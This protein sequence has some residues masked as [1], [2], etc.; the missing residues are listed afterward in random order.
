MGNKLLPVTIRFTPAAYA[1]ICEIASEQGMSMADVV[2]KGFDRELSD[3]LDNIVYMDYDQGKAIQEQLADLANQMQQILFELHRIG[4]NYNQEIRLRQIAKKY[5]QQ[6]TEIDQKYE[7]IIRRPSW[8][9][10]YDDVQ[11]RLKSKAEYQS[12]LDALE[13]NH[14]SEKN[15]IIQQSQGLDMQALNRLISRYEIATGKAGEILCR[16]LGS[17]GRGTVQGQ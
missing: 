6:R 10:S 14:L 16:M 3:Y 4:I 13:E 11:R 17:A 2:R 1:A 15:G 7:K 12:E 5:S 9:E 8:K